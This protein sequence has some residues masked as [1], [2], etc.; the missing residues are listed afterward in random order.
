MTRCHMRHAQ[1]IDVAF[2]NGRQRLGRLLGTW[3]TIALIAGSLLRH[4]VR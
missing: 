3:V 4:T 2:T 1:S